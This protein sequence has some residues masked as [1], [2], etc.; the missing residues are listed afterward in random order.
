MHVRELVD[1][2]GWLV[3]QAPGTRWRPLVISRSAMTYYWA[4]SRCRMDRWGFA[5]KDYLARRETPAQASPAEWR[6]LRPVLEEILV[7]ELLTRVWGAMV[8]CNGAH[9]QGNELS[10]ITHNIMLGHA[11]ARHRALQIVMEAQGQHLAAATEL[12]QLRRRVERWNDT[13]IGA[14][15]CNFDATGAAFDLDRAAGLTS[16][17]MGRAGEAAGESTDW[18]LA[19]LR[20]AFAAGLSPQAPNA[21]LNANIAASILS[22]LDGTTFDDLGL[23]Q[24]AWLARLNSR[25]ATAEG[26]VETALLESQPEPRVH[27]AD[28]RSRLRRPHF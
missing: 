7:S 28:G 13:L 19:S 25:T 4:Q 26:L 21:D 12:N 5:L 16:D 1:L 2:A 20:V 3:T 9:A 24:S 6:A 8:A 17:L 11:D 22:C 10:P 27:R 15:G 23:P 14:L 18:L